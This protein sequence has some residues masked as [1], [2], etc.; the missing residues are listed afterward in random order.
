MTMKNAPFKIALNLLNNIYLNIFVKL[1]KCCN[2]G[3]N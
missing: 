3:V 2:F 1:K